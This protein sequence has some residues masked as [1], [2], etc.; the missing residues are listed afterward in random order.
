MNVEQTLQCEISPH[1]GILLTLISYDRDFLLQFMAV[2]KEKPDSLPPLDSIG[3]EPVDQTF[4]MTRGGSH[5]R[6]SSSA[7]MPPPS[8]QA[9][10]GLGISGFNN[11][12]S[13]VTSFE[14]WELNGGSGAVVPRKAHVSRSLART[15]RRAASG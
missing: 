3:L 12:P 11:K 14:G 6:R 13:S 15:G 5:S 10:V 2:C 4:P 8:R 7:A 1:H 9:S